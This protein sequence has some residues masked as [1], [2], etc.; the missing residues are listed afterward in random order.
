MET[1]HLWDRSQIENMEQRYRA[2]FIN[3]LPCFKT[4]FLVGTQNSLNQTNLAVI[5]SVTHIGSHPPLMSM[6]MRPNTVARH[7]IENLR[8]TGFFTLNA[9]KTSRVADAHQTS[10]R[11]ERDVS[12]FEKC[13]FTPIWEDGIEAPFVL[14]SSLQIGLRTAQ[15]IHLEINGCD[16]VIGEVLIVKAPY[17]SIQA[18]GAI[19]IDQLDL[20]AVSGLDRYHKTESIGRYCYAKPDKKPFKITEK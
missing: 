7:T 17:N 11:Y 13:N 20:A 3:S 14:E 8:E 6:V 19:D 5:S 16:L 15:I 9:T 18:D 2:Q 4:P 10:A 1:L 12:E